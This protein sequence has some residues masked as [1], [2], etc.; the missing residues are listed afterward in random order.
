MREDSFKTLLFDLDGTLTD[1]GVGITSSV[2]YAL[3][4]CGIS[5][6][7]KSELECFIGPPLRESFVRFYGMTPTR[8]D[9]AVAKYRE[10]YNDCGIFENEVYPGI[11]ELL[12]S[13]KEEEKTVIMATSKPECYAE[14]IA[15]HFGISGYFDCITGSELDGRRTDK[16]QV[17]EYALYRAGVGIA[18]RSECVMIGDRKHDIIGA[19]RTGLF[20][21]GVLWG[22]GSLAELEGSGADSVIGTVGELSEMLLCLR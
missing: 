7:D 20:S 1:P 4:A 6:P 5:A 16:A 2:A 8:A 12:A 9:H 17:I 13:L 14:R 11:P 3:E 19:K 15:G 21:V 22:Y 18:D 10:Y